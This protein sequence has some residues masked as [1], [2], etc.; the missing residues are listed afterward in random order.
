MISKVHT[1]DQHSLQEGLHTLLGM[2]YTQKVALWNDCSVPLQ[3]KPF[4]PI[5]Y[6]MIPQ[7]CPPVQ[8]YL[9]IRHSKKYVTDDEAFIIHSLI[10]DAYMNRPAFQKYIDD[11]CDFINDESHIYITK[12]FHE[13]IINSKIVSYFSIR[14]GHPDP[15]KRKSALHCYL[16][17]FTPKV[18]KITM[19]VNM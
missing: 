11:E 17:A 1:E 2:T 8:C 4:I 3:S 18:F 15:E 5:S 19:V 14:I 16:D 9:P 6:R 13:E 7:N 12:G 10:C